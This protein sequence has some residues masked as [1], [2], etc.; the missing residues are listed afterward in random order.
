L[1][2]F[3]QNFSDTKRISNPHTVVHRSQNIHL[4][5]T[6][7]NVIK[8]GLPKVSHSVPSEGI[9]QLRQQIVEINFAS[10]IPNL[11]SV[12]SGGLLWNAGTDLG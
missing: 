3:F 10:R 12:R 8:F 6:L 2:Q 11:S 1:D 7:A 9:P 4:Y 5:I